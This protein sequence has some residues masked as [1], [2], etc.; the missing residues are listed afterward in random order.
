[1]PRRYGGTTP[2]GADLNRIGQKQ[3]GVWTTQVRNRI[4]TIIAFGAEEFQDGKQVIVQST[5]LYRDGIYSFI[6]RLRD[7]QETGFL[8]LV[9][10]ADG[11]AALKGHPSQLLNKKCLITFEGPSVNRGKIIDVVDDFTDGVTVGANNQLQIRGAA[12]APPGNGII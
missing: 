4:G 2:L 10:R 8:P 7:G 12:F 6:V 9:G 3:E 5:E 11:H 1:M